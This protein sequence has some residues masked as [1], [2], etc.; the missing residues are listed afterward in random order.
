MS[1]N[2]HIAEGWP[3]VCQLVEE[4]LNKR[5]LRVDRVFYIGGVRHV[6]ET[7]IPMKFKD[8]SREIGVDNASAYRW[9]RKGTVPDLRNQKIVKAWTKKHAKILTN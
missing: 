3:E 7:E 5:R 8:F 2:H 4:I 1:K 6:A 9:I